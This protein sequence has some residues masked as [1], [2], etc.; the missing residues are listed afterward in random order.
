MNIMIKTGSASNALTYAATLAPKDAGIG[1]CCLFY[2]MMRSSNHV[3]HVSSIRSLGF[4]GHHC[5]LPWKEILIYLL[6]HAGAVF[7]Y[8]PLC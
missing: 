3:A 1:P 2:R 7:Y 5:F 8:K 6:S 4:F